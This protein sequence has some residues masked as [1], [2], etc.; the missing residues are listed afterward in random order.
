[1]VE[2]MV[3]IAIIGLLMA[4]L[5]PAISS[6][7]ESARRTQCLNKMR[8]LAS[9]VQQYENAHRHYPGWRNT[10]TLADPTK[11]Q[12]LS[13]TVLAMP[14]LGRK[15]LY[16]Q[17][18]QVGC[19]KSNLV[20][21]RGIAVCPSDFTKMQSTGPLTSYVGNTG[22]ADATAVLADSNR[23]PP[24]WRTNGVFLDVLA[25]GTPPVNLL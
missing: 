3:V 8:Q 15:D 9:A 6:V 1:M 20:S 4:L 22:R 7:R 25:K 13:W 5:L 12:R 14:Y 11:S 21:L 2:L 10:F 16:E 18:K 17:L 24:D 19:I 23:V